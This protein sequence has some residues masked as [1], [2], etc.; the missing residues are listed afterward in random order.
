MTAITKILNIIPGLA[1]CM[2]ALVSC[3]REE[4]P[5][6]TAAQ[7][8]NTL[9]VHISAG[10]FEGEAQTKARDTGYDHVD[11]AV[12][13]GEGRIVRNIKSLYDRETSTIRLEGLVPGSYELLV[14]AVD[15]DM[16]ADRA[17]INEISEVSDTWLAF[18]EKISG[19][20]AAEYFYSRTPFSVT[21][22][23]DIQG[24]GISSDLDG[25]ITQK[26]IVGK[27]VFRCSYSSP[28]ISTA[29]TSATVS[30][31]SPAF[32]REL[33]AA[34]DFGG[35]A[36]G[37][38]IVLDIKEDSSFIFPPTAGGS[39]FE[40]TL[41]MKTRDYLGHSIGRSYGFSLEEVGQN[42]IG[43]IGISVIHP[44]DQSGT[45]FITREAYA[46]GGH[47]AILQDDEPHTI[48]ND[49]EQRNFNTARPLQV[50][51]TP[52][53]LLHVRFYSPREARN[54]LIRGLIPEVDNEYLDLA[55][56]DV[57]PAF[58]DFYEPLAILEKE[59]GGKRICRSESGR[60]VEVPG[61]G[62]SVAE[63]IMFR[64]ES[65]DPYWQKLQK[66]VHGWNIR[67][68][69][70][71]GDPTK[72]DGG[73]SGNWMGIRPVHC[74][75]VVA[76]FINFTYMIDMPEHEQILR[77]NEDRLYGNGGVEDKVSAETVLSQMR[78]ER[79][80]NAGLVYPGNSVMGLGGGSTFGAWQGGWL[81]HYTSTYSCEVMFHELGHVMGYS[82]NSAFTY[83]PWAQELM[84]R[85]YVDHLDMMPVDSPDYLS[86]R[87]N[88]NIY[89]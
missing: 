53:G 73:P 22:S 27:T 44:D 75:E 50:S 78:Q 65:D 7:T 49:K 26:R 13:D 67:F 45:M 29:V 79:T 34:G 77:E 57:I 39:R 68:E 38:G 9:S 11:I 1:L 71:G 86:S 51:V 24:N 40:G 12:A 16:A 74:R 41:E 62:A 2:A 88:P 54:V 69:L 14:L 10:G 37:D 17:S 23:P 20:L 70:F 64:A 55:Y 5:G 82:H 35:R 76:F 6:M 28:Y 61:I 42:R 58:A 52:E 4:W 33:S 19:P 25:S 3:S 36:E 80:I 8:G 63:R 18:P 87:Q 48:Y 15:G 30:V 59:G 81:D 66:I 72:P 47:K 56:F 21:A 89:K 85:F 32:L 84:N 31:D 43:H 60:L 83:G 46:Q